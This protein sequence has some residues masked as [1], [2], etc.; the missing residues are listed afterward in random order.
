MGRSSRF[1]LSSA[2]GRLA[3]QEEQLREQGELNARLMREIET[4]KTRPRADNEQTASED[5]PG[6]VTEIRITGLFHTQFPDCF[7]RVPFG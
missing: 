4:L 6:C 1:T 7:L 5:A 3:T 2:V